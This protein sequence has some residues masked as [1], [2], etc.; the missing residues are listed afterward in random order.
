M[1]D[2]ETLSLYLFR[3]EISPMFI[4]KQMNISSTKFE[5]SEE[6]CPNVVFRMDLNYN[7]LINVGEFKTAENPYYFTE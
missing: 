5:D 3:N 2:Q 7:N 1:Y 4:D 6:T